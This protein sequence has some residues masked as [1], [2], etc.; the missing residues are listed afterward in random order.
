MYSAPGRLAP[1]SLSLTTTVSEPFGAISRA[2]SPTSA[3]GATT[4]ILG[5]IGTLSLLLWRLGGVKRRDIRRSSPA[6][7][8]RKVSPPSCPANAGHPVTADR[9]RAKEP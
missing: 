2:I 8:G 4:R 7:Q 1:T 9:A 5:D 6:V 3:D